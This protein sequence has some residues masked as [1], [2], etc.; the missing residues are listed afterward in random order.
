MS[1]FAH[2]EYGEL[3]VFWMN[4]ELHKTVFL[5]PCAVLLYSLSTNITTSPDKLGIWHIMNLYSF[6]QF[7]HNDIHV[8]EKRIWQLAKNRSDKIQEAHYTLPG[9]I[10][11]TL[12][13]LQTYFSFPDSPGGVFG[14][15]LIF[16]TWMPRLYFRVEDL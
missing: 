11:A 5:Q 9:T 13:W 8:E 10:P 6:Y 3:Q 1:K 12:F 2:V 4:R 15:E 14:N 7:A 16:A